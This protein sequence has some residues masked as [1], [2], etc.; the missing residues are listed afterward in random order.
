ME[1][2]GRLRKHKEQR[3]TRQSIVGLTETGKKVAEQELAHGPTYVIL[4]KLAEI[5]HCT[6]GD[7][8]DETGLDDNEIKMRV[9][10]LAHQGYVRLSGLEE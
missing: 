7:L 1:L 8:A 4:S 10:K 6:I 9:E 5:P 2:F 3:L